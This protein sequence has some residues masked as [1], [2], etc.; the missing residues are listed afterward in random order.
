MDKQQN[1]SEEIDLLYFFNPV[2]QGVRKYILCLQRNFGWFLFILIIT[3]A[4]GYSSRFFLPK[5]FRTNAIFVSYNLPAS[6]SASMVNNLQA[7]TESPKN[8]TVL[9]EQLKIPVSSASSIQSLSTETMN[10]FSDLNNRDTTASAFKIFLTVD[11]ANNIPI[12][13]EGL[14][15]FLENNQFSIKRR[16]AKRQT[17]EAMRNNFIEQIKGLDTLKNILNSS[18]IPQVH[19]QGIILGEPIS[20]IEAYQV[21]Q[22]FYSQQK[23]VE[24][25]LALLKNIEVLQPFQRIKKS[26]YPNYNLILLYSLLI[27]FGMA[28]ILTPFV[29]KR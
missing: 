9:A 22:K 11:D 24:E 23:E 16:E 6:Y 2:I 20:P 4:I 8:A 21:M 15:M 12:I 19:G 10:S 28:L 27:G 29:G 26:N 17:L 1:N 18:V 14:R 3:I 25:Q 5:Y 13:Q 7:L